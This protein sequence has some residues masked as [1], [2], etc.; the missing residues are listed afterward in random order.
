MDQQENINPSA[1]LIADSYLMGVEDKIDHFLFSVS[2]IHLK[3][4]TVGDKFTL[5]FGTKIPI[6]IG[7]YKNRH[8]EIKDFRFSA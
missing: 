4:K 8:P 6:E 3:E 7:F 1:I 5:S 2:G